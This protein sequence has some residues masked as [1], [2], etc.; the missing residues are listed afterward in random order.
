MK[1]ASILNS[2]LLSMLIFYKTPYS[3]RSEA[4]R[5][6]KQL[7]DPQSGNISLAASHWLVSDLAGA[8]SSL[9][10]WGQQL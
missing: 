9:R 2:A 8:I 1:S 7:F 10:L 6:G 4:R 5:T 3:T